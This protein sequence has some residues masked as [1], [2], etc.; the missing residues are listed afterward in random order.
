MKEETKAKVKQI[1]E[2]VSIYQTS[3]EGVDPESMKLLKE[4][5]QDK[6]QELNKIKEEF[7]NE[8]EELY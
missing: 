1:S 6:E 3:I 4:D 2:I 5:L 7:E 8:L